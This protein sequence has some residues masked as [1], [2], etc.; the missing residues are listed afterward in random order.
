MLDRQATVEEASRK[1]SIF[2]RR[3]LTKLRYHKDG[4][5]A[6]EPQEKPTKK[7]RNRNKKAVMHSAC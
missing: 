6:C 1:T 7:R 2:A 5:Y 3:A 4:V